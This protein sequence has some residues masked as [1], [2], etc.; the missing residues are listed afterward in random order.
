[1]TRVKDRQKRKQVWE[2]GETMM[3]SYYRLRWMRR[4]L[5][6]IFLFSTI[7]ILVNSAAFFGDTSVSSSISPVDSSQVDESAAAQP[8]SPDI[9]R[10][11]YR[12]LYSFL[13]FSVI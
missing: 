6:I 5:I 4:V 11:T 12:F 1:M 8:N 2:G 13:S 9:T 10:D 3:T 7:M